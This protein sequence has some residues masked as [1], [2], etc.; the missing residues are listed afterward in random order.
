MALPDK[1]LTKQLAEVGV[2]RISYGPGPYRLA[3][4][5]LKDAGRKA[6]AMS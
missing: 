2:A 4:N 6:F 1:S 5:A 3:I